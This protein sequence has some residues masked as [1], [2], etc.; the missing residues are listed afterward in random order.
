MIP[1]LVLFSLHL[2]KSFTQE[3]SIAYES[4]GKF[5]LPEI[6]ERQIFSEV[7]DS[8]WVDKFGITHKTF[9]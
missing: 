3:D 8:V 1:I 5:S 9:K 4:R 2:M 7:V 6:D